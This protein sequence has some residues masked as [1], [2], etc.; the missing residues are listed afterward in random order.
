MSICYQML[1]VTMLRM[2]DP[3]ARF[4]SP[5]T[6][7]HPMNEFDFFIDEDEFVVFADHE[8]GFEECDPGLLAWS[9]AQLA[10][11]D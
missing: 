11:W 8:A 3:Y 1:Y 9:E 7:G 5:T 6:K 10:Y 2:S 4:G